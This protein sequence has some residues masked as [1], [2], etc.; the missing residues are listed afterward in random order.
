MSF[1]AWGAQLETG[2]T[3]PYIPTTTAAVSVGITANIPRL[4]YTGGGCP[5]LLL[6]PQ[7]TNLALFS[8]QLD[9]AAWTKNNAPTILSNVAVAP[10]GTISADSIADTIGT[11]YKRVSQIY[12]ITP[13][14][15][16]TFTFFVKKET[17]KTNFGGFSFDYIGGS[18]LFCRIAFNEVTGAI[19]I[20]TPSNI[21][22]ILK[23]E[24]YGNY[25]RFSITATDT[26]TNTSVEAQIWGNI[27][28]DGT[29]IG[30]GIGSARTIWGCQFEAGSY[31]T[32]YIPTLGSSV[33]R[34]ADAASK[35]GISSLIGQ[36][37]GVL[38][39]EGTINAVP[40]DQPIFG[41]EKEASS[42]VIRFGGDGTSLYAQAFNGSTNLFFQT[43]TPSVGQ[44]IKV[45]FAYK[46][47]DYAFYK[48]GTL[49]ASGTNASTIPACDKLQT[50]QLWSTSGGIGAYSTNDAALYTTRLSNAELQSLTAL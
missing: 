3:T 21:T 47:G 9:N 49:V 33:T 41:V 42:F 44:K 10:D 25:W 50:N 32:S 4:D 6:E 8:E 18:Y 45:A 11:D 24:D 37:E 30:L 2:V 39:W 29:S 22:P 36:S 15:T 7:R 17:S 14:G 26:G 19:N 12:S 28:I 27:S 48:N 46:A 34:L 35:T 38:Y 20:L 31:A 16:S 40:V 13:N 5:S 23:S 43:T 1:A